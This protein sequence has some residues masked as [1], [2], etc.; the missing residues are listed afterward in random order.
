MMRCA[1][2]LPCPPSLVRNL[3]AEGHTVDYR[4]CIHVDG[5][6][7]AADSTRIPAGAPAAHADRQ[8]ACRLS[9]HHSC[10]CGP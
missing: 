2:V 1:R 4:S 9:G 8:L 6:K 3:C 5:Y 7:R 10:L